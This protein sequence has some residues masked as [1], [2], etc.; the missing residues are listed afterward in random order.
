LKLPFAAEE[1]VR[2][3]L[4]QAM[5]T[6]TSAVCVT[7]LTVVDTVNSYTLFGELVILCLIQLGG[8]GFMFFATSVL[9]LTGR[10]ISLRNRMLLHETMSMPGLSGSVRMTMRFMLIVMA[11]EL[12]GSIILS[13][14]F[15]P[16]YGFWK[17]IYFGFFHAISAF[18]NAGFDLFGTAGSLRS[19]NQQPAVLLTVS[20]LIIVG[21]LG[22]TVLADL[23]DQRF[24]FKK[25]HLHSKIV[26][27]VSCFLLVGGALIIALIEWDNPETL[28]HA[29]AGPFDKAMNAW[30][31]STTARTAGYYSFWQAK[32]HD[33]SK[34]VTI[35]LMFIGASPASTGG[36]IKTTTIFTLVMLIRSVFHGKEDVSAFHRRLPNILVR[37]ALSIFFISMSLLAAGGVIMSLAEHSDGYRMIDLI[38]EEAS[39]LGTVGLSSADTMTLSDKSQIWLI[40]LMYFGRVGPL[41]MMLSLSRRNAAK[42]AGMRYSEEQIIV[43]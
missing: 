6:A 27:T 18:C 9:V 7:G 12:M 30:F 8:L 11:V 17:G 37:T 4:L 19:F 20:G 21:G 29:G 26:L 38:F 33:S 24:R 34:L 25:L 36:G 41:T 43:G 10:R 2:I 16:L 23:L 35:V 13:S 39:A 32:L 14:Q 28:A 15:V 31:Q 1:G 3:S 40:M 5:F 22:F 42:S